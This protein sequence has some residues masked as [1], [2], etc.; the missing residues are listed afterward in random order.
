MKRL[1]VAAAVVAA[2]AALTSC[3]NSVPGGSLKT[4]TDTL[5]YAIG[6]AQTQGLKPYLAHQVGV[7]TTYMDDF[8]AG[9][10]DG[11]RS[12]SDKKKAAYYAGVNIG[13]QIGGQM[14]DGINREVFGEDS[15]QSVPLDNILAGFAA[16]ATGEKGLMTTE[17]ARKTAQLKMKELKSR[18]I[19]KEFAANREEGEK[20]LA[21]LRKDLG[22]NGL[23]TLPGGVMYK[24]L[25]QGKGPIP[26]DSSR[27]EINYEGRLTDGTVFETTYKD[28]NGD[29]NVKP[30]K[31]RVNSVIKGWREALTKMPQGSVWEV[32]IPQ[33]MAYGERSMG[34]I[35][36]YSALVF[37]IELLDANVK[38]ATKAKSGAKAKAKK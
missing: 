19:E 25:K 32:Y 14:L 6:I 36:P 11:A 1:T 17:Q 34:K 27:V 28:K 29:P 16:G 10:V 22:K 8:V 26:T 4:E 31:L 2:A 33:E 24:V 30:R 35:K 21:G 38:A 3:G 37:K 20:Y 5:G 9:L 15:T 23:D 18:R 7:D 13:Q 12:V